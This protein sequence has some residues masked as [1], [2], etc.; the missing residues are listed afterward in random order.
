MKNSHLLT[1]KLPGNTIEHTEQLTGKILHKSILV[2]PIIYTL[3]IHIF[4]YVWL[5]FSFPPSPPELCNID[6][7]AAQ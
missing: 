5:Y 2:T 3:V 6:V 7:P 4:T 1:K